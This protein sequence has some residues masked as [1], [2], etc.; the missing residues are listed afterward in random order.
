MKHFGIFLITI[1]SLNISAYTQTVY[2]DTTEIKKNVAWYSPSNATIVNGVMFNV[3]PVMINEDTKNWPKINGL[4]IEISPVSIFSPF[5]AVINSL[6]ARTHQPV[7][8]SIQPLIKSDFKEINGLHIGLGD[9]ESKWVNGI[10]ISA[11]GSFFSFVNGASISLFMNKHYKINGVSL[12]A[13]GN[14]DI[15]TN[16]IQIG[17]FNSSLKLYGVQFGLW[18]KNQKRSLPIINWVLK[19]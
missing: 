4:E 17:L 10:D 9:M 6:A 7:D 13:F 18:N 8:D 14:H 19:K 12:A 2:R 11:T 5:L 3:F 1:F 16:G 15:E